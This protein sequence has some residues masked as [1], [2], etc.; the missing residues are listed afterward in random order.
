MTQRIYRTGSSDRRYTEEGAGPLDLLPALLRQ[1]EA[2]LGQTAGFATRYCAF[3]G[4][5]GAASRLYFAS[6]V[7]A[8]E[9]LYM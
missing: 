3:T 4:A 5:S 2:P 7:P 8:S 9:A 6:S 1:H